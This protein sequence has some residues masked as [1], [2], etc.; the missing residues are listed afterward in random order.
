[1]ALP[2]AQQAEA[3]AERLQLLA[4]HQDVPSSEI[5]PPGQGTDFPASS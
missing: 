5:P 4:A 1:L 3:G 2:P